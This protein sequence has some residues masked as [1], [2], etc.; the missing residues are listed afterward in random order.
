MRGI[1]AFAHLF[2]A[3]LLAGYALFWTRMARSLSTS[4]TSDA[5]AR[6]VPAEGERP[7]WEALRRF[8]WP[9]PPAPTPLRLSLAG[10]G[11][12][13]LLLLA[14]TGG[15]L[16]AGGGWPRIL[17]DPW[18]SRAGRLLLLKGGLFAVLLAAHAALSRR[19]GAGSAYALAALT[20][21]VVVVAALMGR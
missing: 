3:V 2:G 13:L 5:D 1:V 6:G 21:L 19:P 17:A 10:L 11:W 9:P 7:S 18:A 15:V 20:A 8:R 14:A 4:S 16:L 12:S